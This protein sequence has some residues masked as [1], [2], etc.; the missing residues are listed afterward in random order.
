VSQTALLSLRHCTLVCEKPSA[1]EVLRMFGD[2]GESIF[3]KSRKILEILKYTSE[4]T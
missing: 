2:T 1:G 3:E 4:F